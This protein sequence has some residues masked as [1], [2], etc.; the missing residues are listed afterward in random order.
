M[1]E[2]VTF[3]QNI[4]HQLLEI[5]IKPECCKRS[6]ITGTELFARSR[7]NEFTDAINEYKEKLNRKK[8][9]AFFEDSEPAGYVIDSE[10]GVVLPV[11]SGRICPNCF[12]HMIRGAFLVC[13]RASK[14]EKNLHLEMVMPSEEVR[15]LLSEYLSELGFVPKEAIRRGEILLYYKKYETVEDF[16]TYIGASATTLDLMN[17]AIMSELRTSVN[18]QRN[19]DTGNIQKTVDAANRQTDAIKAII[20]FGSLKDLP[21]TLRQTAAIRLEHP[22]DSLELITELHGGKISRSGVNHRLQRIVDYAEKM[23]YLK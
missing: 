11:S 21:L 2:N 13:G 4:K 14:S 7:K 8:R 15:M 20:E 6:F 9:K 12:S 10:S 18:R 1:S 5:E 3:V 16:L 19:C 22:L 17:S 23:G